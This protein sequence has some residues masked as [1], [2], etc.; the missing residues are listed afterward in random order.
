[1]LFNVLFKSVLRFAAVLLA[2]ASFAATAVIAKEPRVPP[3][4]S[5]P[6]GVVIAL[7]GPGVDYRLSEIARSLSR[8]GEGDLIG[9]DFTDNDIKPFAETG[10]G[11]AAAVTLAGLAPHSQLVVIK[12]RPGDPQALGHM[13]AFVSRTPARIVVWLE[14]DPKRADW[15]IL[16]QAVRGLGDRLFVIPAGGGGRDLDTSQAY[17]GIRGASNLIIVTGDA[18]NANRGNSTVDMKIVGTGGA[19]PL[20]SQDAALVVAAI[21]ARALAREPRQSMADL[22]QRI[23]KPAPRGIASRPGY[24][25]VAEANAA[26]PV[27]GR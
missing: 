27:T 3:G 26:F 15:P 5:R 22:K 14:A 20:T 6:G 10:L 21:A 1:M 16:A 24:M 8:D 12:E 23:T 9:W 17:K 11:T 25:S 19:L 7:V 2:V 18:S 13:M 4:L